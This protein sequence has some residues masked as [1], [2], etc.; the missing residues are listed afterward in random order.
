MVVERNLKFTPHLIGYSV[1]NGKIEDGS[2]L[3]RLPKI[4][5]FLRRNQIIF[6]FELNLTRLLTTVSRV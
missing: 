1:W 2:K 6:T 4:G 5:N 3:K